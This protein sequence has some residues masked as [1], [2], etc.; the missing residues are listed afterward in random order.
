LYWDGDELQGAHLCAD[1][2]GEVDQSF[3]V[4]DVLPEIA[5]GVEDWLK[6]PTFSFR[7]SLLD[8]LPDAPPVDRGI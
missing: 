8:W 7:Q 5:D 2:P 1:R 3:N 6:P 4:E